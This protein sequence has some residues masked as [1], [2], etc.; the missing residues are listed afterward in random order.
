MLGRIVREYL[1]E[2][3][4]AYPLGEIAPLMRR[5]DLTLVN[6]ECAITASRELWRGEPK[7]F[8]F[9]APVEAARSLVDAGV[10]LVSL[11]NN[12][13]LD[14]EVQGL[15]DTLKALDAH[16]IGH[17]GAGRNLAEARRPAVIERKGIKFAMVAYCDHQ[18]DFAASDEAPG[19]AYLD[20]A[21]TESALARLRADLAA[22]RQARVDWPMLSLH[23]GPN[24]VN[25]PSQQFVRIAHAAVDMGW[26]LLFGH[27]AH[28]FHGIELYRGCPIFYAA[29]DLVDD[30][31]VDPIFRNDHQ[32]LF[33]LELDA[34]TLRRIRLH[35]VF[36]EECRTLPASAG[37][38]AYIAKRAT[39]L[40]E[41]LGTRVRQR[42]S[43][44]WIDCVPATP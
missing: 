26:K 18:E 24:M 28:V 37:Q 7:A 16:H 2:R 15:L 4:P 1:R 36:I 3:G 25:R 22:L 30:Y 31:H 32:L 13:I 23:W 43:G 21:D 35:P 41:E 38:F 27:S 20:L 8:Y 17:A 9:G 44:L 40:C 42:D 10:D 19:I 12:H 14:F 34:A 33:E 11:A 39:G 6:L 5:T 29:G